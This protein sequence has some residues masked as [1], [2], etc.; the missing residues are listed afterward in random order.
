MGALTDA[1]L[2]NQTSMTAHY[3][4]TLRSDPGGVISRC[5]MTTHSHCTAA[6][7]FGSLATSRDQS[8]F[9]VSAPS[10]R[11]RVLLMLDASSANRAGDVKSRYKKTNV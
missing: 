8:M 9:G 10:D 5:Q 3:A 4:G 1:D 6:A 2:V 7:L 11:P